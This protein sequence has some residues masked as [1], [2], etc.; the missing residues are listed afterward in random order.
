[1]AGDNYSRY[2]PKKSAPPTTKKAKRAKKAETKDLIPGSAEAEDAGLAATQRTEAARL[3]QIVNLLI[4]G[5]SLAQIGIATGMTADEV[6]RL[7]Q[8]DGARY[9]RNQPQLRVFMRNWLSSRYTALLDSTFSHATDDNDPK[10][11]EYQDRVLRTLDSL[12][13]LHG[14]DVP[15]QTEI[16]IEAAPENVEAMVR[17][18]SASRGQGYDMEVFDVEV[19][20]V[21]SEVEADGEDFGSEDRTA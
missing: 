4:G 7:I 18:L 1:M 10:Q 3:A 8:A 5:Y 13:K 17:A 21:D 11:L 14:V 12:R 20:E 2:G 16:K 15:T 9:V 19:E 6:D